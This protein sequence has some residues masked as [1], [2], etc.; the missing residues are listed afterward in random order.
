MSRELKG[1]VIIVAIYLL[2]MLIS[3]M[4]GGFISSNI[5]GMLILFG[6]L[7]FGVIKEEDVKSVCNFIL[8]NMMLLFVPIVVGIMGS[9]HLITENWKE[10]ITTLLLSTIIVIVVVGSVQQ[11]FGRRWRR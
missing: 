8:K 11:Y 9:Y 1:V 6:T 2:G 4:I 5:I 10:V 7:Q 3:K